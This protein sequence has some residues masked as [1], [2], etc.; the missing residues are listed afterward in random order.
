MARVARALG[1]EASAL[2]LEGRPS[3]TAAEAA[4]VAEISAEDSIRSTVLV[5]SPLKSYRPARAFQRTGFDVVSA[6]G[7]AGSAPLVVAEDHLVRHL[8][9]IFEALHEYAIVAA[10]W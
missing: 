1:I 9:L 2:F 5:T 8:G 6:S 10:Y 7:M 3:S 4:S